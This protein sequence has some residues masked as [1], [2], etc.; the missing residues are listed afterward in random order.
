MVASVLLAYL[1]PFASHAE[2]LPP[3]QQAEARC[4][5]TTFRGSRQ[6]LAE[7]AD[8]MGLHGKLYGCAV[9]AAARASEVG[10][11]GRKG[12]KA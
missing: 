1:R 11:G 4:F 9:P 12:K 10:K 5:E 2:V 7:R 3:L 8:Q 6:E